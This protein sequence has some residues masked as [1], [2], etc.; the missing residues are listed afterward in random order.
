MAKAKIRKVPDL[1]NDYLKCR[2][3]GHAWEP[4]SVY[5]ERDG[6]RKY[7]RAEW[8][9]LRCDTLRKD[10]VANNGDI[11]NR[12]YSYASGYC[13]KD[14]ENL[15]GRL[16]VNKAVRIVLLQRLV[17]EANRLSSGGDER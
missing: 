4:V 7:F 3:V 13:L 15:G 2:M 16:A 10:S 17:A 5:V 1:A 9:C 11:D 14:I 6:G 12:G 8:R